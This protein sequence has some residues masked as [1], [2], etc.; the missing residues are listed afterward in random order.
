MRHN[1]AVLGHLIST[2]FPQVDG[3][4]TN[5]RILGHHMGSMV[6]PIAS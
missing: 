1:S 4:S 5:P 2:S 3:W 6:R